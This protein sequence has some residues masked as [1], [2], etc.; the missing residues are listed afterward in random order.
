[1]SFVLSH[2]WT[3]TVIVGAALALGLA[4]VLAPVA[5]PAEAQALPDL[6]LTVPSGSPNITA[7]AGEP[8]AIAH[9]VKNVGSGHARAGILWRVSLPA[10]FRITF[11]HLTGW[12][13]W[14]LSRSSDRVDAV[15]A[16]VMPPGAASKLRVDATVPSTPGT[17]QVVSVVDVNQGQ[18][19]TNENNNRGV[20]TITVVP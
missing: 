18:T 16:F 2:L 12:N 19:E 13:G 9:I 11:V 1:M 7:H 4:A 5:P 20:T 17:Y 14:R 8:V 6:E 10:G 15:T 3:R